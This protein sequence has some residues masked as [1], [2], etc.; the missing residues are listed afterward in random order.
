MFTD[1]A[2]SISFFRKTKECGSRRS[3]EISSFAR[4][5]PTTSGFARY[6]F[7]WSPFLISRPRRNRLSVGF[8]FA[9]VENFRSSSRFTSERD[10]SRSTGES[11]HIAL[12]CQ[13]S[14]D[15]GSEHDY[16]AVSGSIPRNYH[17]RRT[18]ARVRQLRRVAKTALGANRSSV[19]RSTAETN[20]ARDSPDSR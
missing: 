14:G 8:S 20:P 7:P 19:Q 10:L 1:F 16:R 4:P 9:A 17:R 15:D 13:D 3:L 5:T 2:I 18:P 12:R 6:E 11:V